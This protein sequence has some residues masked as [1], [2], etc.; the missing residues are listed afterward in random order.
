MDKLSNQI[1]ELNSKCLDLLKDGKADLA[2]SKLKEAESLLESMTNDG[3]DVDRN[4]IIVILHNQACCYQRLKTPSLDECSNYL[5]GTIYNLK[6]TTV[7]EE[8]PREVPNA[9]GYGAYM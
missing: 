4:L 3:H 1:G 5:D 7:F 2:L 9:Y 8:E 6:S